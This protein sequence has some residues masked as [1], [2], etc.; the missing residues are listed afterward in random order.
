MSHVLF[1]K[2]GQSFSANR[3]T[4]TQRLQVQYRPLLLLLAVVRM[5]LL[6]SLRLKTE[7][8]CVDPVVHV[9]VGWI[10]HGNTEIPL[11]ASTT[12]NSVS[13]QNC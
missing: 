6:Y 9:R 8:P 13:F 5:R 2:V 11:P 10:N 12:R 3:S 1:A 4:K 7:G